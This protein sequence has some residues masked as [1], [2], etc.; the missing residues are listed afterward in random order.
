[1]SLTEAMEEQWLDE[2]YAEY[3]EV[4]IEE[5]TSQRLQSF[6]LANPNIIQPLSQALAEGKSLLANHP[7]AAFIF[8][9]IAIEVGLKNLILHPVVYGLVHSKSTADL[10]TKIVMSHVSIEKFKKL[11][12]HILNEHIGVDLETFTRSNAKKTLWKEAD[13]IKKKR[14]AVMHE[15]VI[16]TSDEAQESLEVA[17]F[18]LESLFPKLLDK[19]GLVLDD[20]KLVM[21]KRKYEYEKFLDQDRT[22]KDA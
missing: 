10:I 1:M 2:L 20:N 11:L 22:R 17:T 5:F 9:A 19:L 6:Y 3:K 16:V 4:A 7:R 12:F 18:I 15:A 14:N 13:L 21:E 8:A